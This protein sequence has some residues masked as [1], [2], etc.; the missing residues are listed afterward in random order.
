MKWFVVELFHHQLMI[1]LGLGLKNIG[2][3]YT[4]KLPG[5]THLSNYKA[6]AKDQK[7][8]NHLNQNTKRQSHPEKEI[9]RVH[10]KIKNQ[11]AN[12]N[13]LARNQRISLLF[14]VPLM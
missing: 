13:R 7:E 5:D 8:K 6:N 4:M 2:K 9:L 12:T 1:T 11:R 3:S 14:T 10:Q